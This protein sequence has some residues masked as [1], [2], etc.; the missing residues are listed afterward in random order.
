MLSR[1]SLALL[2]GS[3]AL[4]TGL[5]F[6]IGTAR[7]ADAPES[8][9][10]RIKRTKKLRIGA[11][12]GGEPYYHKDLVAGKWSGFCID[13]AT[14]LASQFEAE[15]EIVESTWGN[16]V[17][18]LE[19]NKIDIMFGV[20]PTP[21]RAFVIDFC[22]PLFTNAF[23]ILAKKGFE[24]KTWA[25]LNDPK[26]KIAVDIG[27]SHD[28]IARRLCPKAE[29]VGFKTADEA[30]LALQT[31]RVD[32]QVLVIILSLTMLK[33]NPN[34][35]TVIIPQPLM[36]TT[37]NPGVRKEADK[38]LRDFVDV[39]VDYNRSVGQIREWVV[40]NLELVGVQAT[41]IPAGVNF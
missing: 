41:D 7:A 22:K 8:T 31:G 37:T 21:K 13:M 20:N 9:F 36:G 40:K 34:V 35:G 26:I 16:A 24:P 6:G 28:Q 32:C 10:D 12:A 14:D 19:A 11:I 17:L 1:R 18:D 29:I 2:A 4:V 15:L 3:A 23:T 39:W 27:S 30:T 5:D 38:S 25:E 33:K